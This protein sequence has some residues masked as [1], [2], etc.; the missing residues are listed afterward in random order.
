[1]FLAAAKI[2]KNASERDT[3]KRKSELRQEEG[4]LATDYTDEIQMN[5]DK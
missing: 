1:M 2:G 5:F 3:G 4:E